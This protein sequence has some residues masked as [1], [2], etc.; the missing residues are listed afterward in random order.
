M[1]FFFFLEISQ[2]SN[3]LIMIKIMLLNSNEDSKV[4]LELKTKNLWA[5]QTVIVKIKIKK[6]II[7]CRI[8]FIA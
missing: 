4:Q 3:P 6:Y 1:I 5:N 7:G 2:W 8:I